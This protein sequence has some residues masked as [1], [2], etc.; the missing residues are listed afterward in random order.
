MDSKTIDILWNTAQTFT[1]LNIAAEIYLF[2]ALLAYGL[3][4]KH[5]PTSL[6]L[7]SLACPLA[8]LLN[9][10]VTQ[11]HLVNAVAPLHNQNGTTA[12][13][14]CNL[15]HRIK[16]GVFYVSALPAFLFLWLRQRILYR[17]PVIKLLFS[18]P[19]AALST[20]AIAVIVGGGAGAVAVK[21]KQSDYNATGY[22][23]VSNPSVE[24]HH[25]V[26]WAASGGF[27]VSLVILFGLFV[28]PLVHHR[29]KIH[30]TGTLRSAGNDDIVYRAIRQ[31][32]VGLSMC[33]LADLVVIVVVSAV[34]PRHWPRYSTGILYDASLL[35][36]SLA[37]VFCY[38]AHCEILAPSCGGG[39]GR[40]DE[41]TPAKSV[42]SN[43]TSV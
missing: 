14:M 28:Y 39:G 35:V 23:C 25:Y 21:I 24:R 12:A 16:A 37:I 20:F 7:V 17:K 22:G 38:D 33:V 41:T 34:F 42:A 26:K 11:V 30:S 10:A 32:A 15:L 40:R 6:F 9:L 4:R 27:A 29:L 36:H 3:H 5:H 19:V 43:L 13:D 1:V 8:S 31:S 18:R 2:V